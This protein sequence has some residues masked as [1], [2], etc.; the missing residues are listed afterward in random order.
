MAQGAKSINQGLDGVLN[1]QDDVRGSLGVPSNDVSGQYVNVQTYGLAAQ[2]TDR[3]T[4]SH[5]NAGVFP[6]VVLGWPREFDVHRPD[7]RAYLI[8]F[9]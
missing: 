5:V 2:V 8:A 1:T 3:K 4:A 9:E 7:N 6:G